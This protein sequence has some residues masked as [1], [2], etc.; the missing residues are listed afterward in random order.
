MKTFRNKQRWIQT[1]QIRGGRKGGEGD[2]HP[3]REISGRP[4][5]KIKKH[6]SVLSEN[7]VGWGGGGGG[8][9]GTPAPPRIR[10]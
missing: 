10:H 1:L 6:F 4:D 3:D 8:G 7:K 2:G 5:L 9:A